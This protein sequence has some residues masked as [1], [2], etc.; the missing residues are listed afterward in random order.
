MTRLSLTLLAVAL[1][2][3]AAAEEADCANAITQKDMN[4]CAEADWQ[5][6]D[7]VLNSTYKEV[8]AAMKQMDAGLPDDL[9]GAEVA[10]RDAQRAWISYRDANCTAAGFKMRGGSAEPLL[11]YGCLL[12]L[13]LT[14]T[15]EL[16]D[17]IA[18]Y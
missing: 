11:V 6:A 15:E 16:Q 10:L 12:Q 18:E 8:M 7:K 4:I 9:R 17:L 5:A 2:L 1:A 14:R 13:T 3:P